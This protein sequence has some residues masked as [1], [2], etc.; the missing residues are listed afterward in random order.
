MPR[1]HI[2]QKILE[3][4]ENP[5]TALS[6]Q[7]LKYR[8]RI[9]LIIEIKLKDLTITDYEL[10]K[11]LRKQNYVHSFAQAVNDITVAERM[12]ASQK[13][14]DADPEKTWDR[15]FISE[16]TKK[17]M[18]IAREK[19][20][21]YT[22]AYAANIYG[23]HKLTDKEDVERPPFDD[24]IPF[25]PEITSDPS[26]LGIKPIPNLEEKKAELMKKYGI[27]EA[28]IIKNETEK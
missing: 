14:P 5:D 8:E 17:A 24:I 20:D 3:S 22:I 12:I 23:K 10:Y 26:V 15:Y 4:F 11:K 13:K 28:E 19:N 1:K 27:Q 21:A 7:E 2:I 25:V 18:R 6:D 16:I 9:V